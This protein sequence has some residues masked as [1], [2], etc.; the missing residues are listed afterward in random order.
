MKKT[1]I[2]LYLALVSAYSYAQF[3]NVAYNN[4]KYFQFKASKTYVV[5]TGDERF[6]TELVNAM[7]DLWKL[8]PVDVI[9]GDKLN[10]KIKDKKN[11]FIISAIVDRFNVIALINGGH[12]NL[13]FYSHAD[14]LAYCPINNEHNEPENTDCYYRIRNMVESMVN[15]MEL[16][17]KNNL[18]GTSLKIATKIMEIYNSRAP[19]IK[20]RTLLFC[21]ESMGDKISKSDITG[22][23]PYKLE[24]CTKEK[25]EQVIKEKSTEYY[26]F[27]PMVTFN[28]MIMVFDPSNGEVLYAALDQML[29]ANINKKDI[30]KFVD[31]INGVK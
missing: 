31:K 1:L 20:N 27:Q 8:T 9:E 7:K 18:K 15:A 28:K 24:F 26:Y 6:D 11:S 17:K 23:Y 22:M 25:I 30:K 29:S 13:N 5:L 21:R 3:S 10:T 4:E 12:Q 16:V 14:M 19:Q 2:L